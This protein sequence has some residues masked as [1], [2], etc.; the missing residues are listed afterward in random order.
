MC[1]PRIGSF[2][3]VEDQVSGQGT[4]PVA[5]SVTDIWLT[6]EYHEREVL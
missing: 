6:A 4:N 3:S 1:V 2:D 5:D